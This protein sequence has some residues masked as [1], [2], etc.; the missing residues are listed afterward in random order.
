MSSKIG[1]IVS[2]VL[3]VGVTRVFVAYFRSENTS[4]LTCMYELTSM[5]AK[6][7][8]TGKMLSCIKPCMHASKDNNI[9]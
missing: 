3:N 1:D 5:C 6:Q 2:Y 7:S 9:K 4:Q 8:V